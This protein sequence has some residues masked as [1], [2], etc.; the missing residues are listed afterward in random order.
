[1]I[2]KILDPLPHAMPSDN[3][4]QEAGENLD[5]I[6]QLSKSFVQELEDNTYYSSKISVASITTFLGKILQNAYDSIYLAN[7][8][9]KPRIVL[10]A[11]KT[12]DMIR[13]TIE[14][15]GRGFLDTTSPINNLK[16]TAKQHSVPFGGNGSA[17]K[18]VFEEL[19]ELGGSI[20][21]E[22]KQNNTGAVIIINLPTK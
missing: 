18:A 15:N 14:D 9:S 4:I 21:R 11:S 10:E 22:N 20:V 7:N 3:Q 6:K 12:E 8:S 5:F 1:M 19:N 17:L 16:S 13:I 2:K